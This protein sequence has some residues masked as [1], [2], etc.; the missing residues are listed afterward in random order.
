[1]ATRSRQRTRR[2]APAVGKCR[3]LVRVS[4]KNLGALAQP[5]CCLACYWHRLKLRFSAP[6]SFFPGIF[7][8]FDVYTKR[9]VHGCFDR[10]GGPP[11]WLADL[12]VVGYV[13]PPHFSRFSLIDETY[14]V[15][16]TG[17]PD[18]VLVRENG[19]HLI[20]DYKTAKFTENQDLLLPTYR[21]QLNAYARIAE[22]CG[23]APISGLA[24]IYLEP[25]T[26]DEP[27]E[28]DG[29]RKYGFDIAFAA[30]VLPVALDTHMIDPL[31]ARVREFADMPSAPP[32]RPGCKDCARV[33]ELLSLGG[34]GGDVSGIV[35]G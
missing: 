4:G 10:T 19:S 23:Y 17:A 6:W 32:G 28:C 22:A 8:T 24:L 27:G 33:A 13:K 26:G 14:G 29:C 30:H 2:R 7:S 11:P 1:M 15:L 35:A 20:A 5:D 12:N 21:V 31:L 16:L 3:E 34:S 25:Q 18:T 9:V